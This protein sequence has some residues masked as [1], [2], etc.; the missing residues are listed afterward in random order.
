MENY[1]VIVVGGGPGGL[2][3]ACAAK[4]A[5]AGR[6]L[7]LERDNRTG[8]ILNQC[9][10]DGFGLIRYKQALAGPEYATRATQEA[11]ACGVEIKCGAMVVDMTA[12]RVITAVSRDGLHTY[13]AGAI[14]LA[15]GCRE[16]TRGAVM[17]PGTRPAG[18][19]TAGVVQ[20]FVNVRNIMIG[21]RVVILGS[22]DIGLIMARRL[23][24]EGAKVLAV[25]ELMPNSGGLQRNISQCLYDFDI[26]LY[27]GHTVSNIYGKRNLSAVEI[28]RVDKDNKP[29]PGSAWTIECDAL[30]LSVGLIPENEVAKSAGIKLDPR[31]NGTVTDGYMQTSVEGIFSCGNSHAVMDLVDFVSAQGEIAGKNAAAFCSGGTMEEWVLSRQSEPAKG[32][33]DPNVLNCILCPNGCRLTYEKDGTISGNKCKRGIQYAQQ[34]RT[35]P[36]RTL[37]L[38]VRTA[39][40]ALVPARTAE[41]VPKAKLLDAVSVLQRITLPNRAYSCGDILV[42]DF[43]GTKVVA[44]ADIQA[45]DM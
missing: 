18:V 11:V 6:V 31:N 39:A 45:S 34:E 14:V 36:V 32:I 9:I 10:H 1:D 15:T 29:I 40:G 8:G 16:R 25:V 41:P 13:R 24:L 30:V 20:N 38:T 17:I 21:R 27:T 28:S 42:E 3:A 22:G 37:T 12:D 44:T 2:A 4:K 19:F 33:P 26:P 5:G 7:V 35:A 43:F 23:T